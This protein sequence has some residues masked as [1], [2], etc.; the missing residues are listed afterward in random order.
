[1]LKKIIL[2]PFLISIYPIIFLF[3]HNSGKVNP[4]ELVFPLFITV[5]AAILLWFVFQRFERDKSKSA[6]LV[7]LF[8]LLFFTYGPVN[9]AIAL[10]LNRANIIEDIW[11]LPLHETWHVFWILLWTTLLGSTA[12][13]LKKYRG[14]ADLLNEI[15]NILS[16]IIMA[17]VSV[18]LIYALINEPR[19][20]IESFSIGW[21]HELSAVDNTGR[22]QSGYRP[23]IYYIILDGYGRADILKAIYALDNSNFTD[24]LISK[25]FYVAD[26]SHANYPA[27]QLSFASSLNFMYLDEVADYVGSGTTNP[28]PLEKMVK[29]NRIMTY[30]ETLG[31]KTVFF[32]DGFPVTNIRNADIYLSPHFWSPSNFQSEIINSTPVPFIIDILGL[33]NE[34]DFHREKILYTLSHLPGVAKTTGPK[35]VLAHIFAP[36][37]PFVFNAKGEYVRSERHFA[38]IDANDFRLAGSQEEYVQGYREQAAFISEQVQ[39]V[40]GEIL[41]VSPQPPIIIIQGDHGPGSMWDWFNLENSNLEERLSILNA[42][43]FPDKNYSQ[44]YPEITPVNSFRVILEQYFGQEYSLLPD[45]SYYFIGDH[46]YKYTEVT[47]RIGW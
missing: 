9:L 31:Y 19:A 1:M 3:A 28:K 22:T 4:Q 42:Y 20:K 33:K 15:P 23:D 24:Y 44:L 30:L 8:F 11:K 18:N 16:L 2:H 34:Y 29:Q 35:F 46:P 38:I 21:E 36:H 27:T 26:R 41:R 5:C 14:K 45:R 7:S 13:L 32:D 12:V 37:P 17:I 6:L 40:V 25:G 39:N 10:F 47:Q 43:Y